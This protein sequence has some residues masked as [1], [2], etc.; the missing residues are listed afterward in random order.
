[1]PRAAPK[2]AAPE[3]DL[4]QLARDDFPTYMTLVHQTDE[5]RFQR[6]AVPA[7]HHVEIM[8]A[9]GQDI[10]GQ[11][12]TV[13]I[14]PRGSAKTTL[15]QAWIEWQIGRASLSGGKDWANNIRVLYLTAT[16][17]QAYHVSNA[18]KNIIAASDIY[19]AIFPKVQPDPTKWA[20]PEW[21]VKG[22][23]IKDST[24]QG[25]GV[26]GPALG[27]R[28]DL[29]VFDD[30]GDE[31]N[32]AT[33]YMR[34]KMCGSEDGQRAGWLDSTATP[35]LVPSGRMVML[36]TR[37]AFWDPPAWAMRS[38]WRTLEMKALQTS[39]SAEGN[40]GQERSYWPERFTLDYL[41]DL[42]RRKP[43]AFARQYQN[44]V[45][46]EEGLLFQRHWFPEPFDWLPAERVFGLDSWDTG[47]ST[48]RNRSFTV[49]LAAAVD[50]DWHI[51]LFH[52]EK[53]QAYYGAVRQMIQMMHERTGSDHVVIE[54]KS[55]GLA[56]LHDSWLSGVPMKPWA[57]PGERGAVPKERAAELVTEY[58]EKGMIHLPSEQFCRR[59]GNP[60]WVPDF[61][62]DVLSYEGKESSGADTVDALVQ[63]VLFVQDRRIRL[64]PLLGEPRRIEWAEPD[65][66]VTVY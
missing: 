38:G 49:G 8:R 56:A 60:Y 59:T 61:L 7:S 65:N 44:E 39:R 31:E 19:H 16:A 58:C 27:A 11:P 53:E 3:V 41:Q 36:A 37:W 62:K 4:L 52:R 48:G 51:Y 55:T 40:E 13:I 25:L 46:P 17:H 57:P 64:E 30:I 6:R 66:R 42:R 12:H 23:T 21:K 45:T 5:E 54:N 9:L 15:V 29:I 24:F 43:A 33:P 20:E 63:L 18:I 47:A 32:M 2:P 50:R 22:N 26:G 34:E 35:I 28:A 14:A 10:H 1:M